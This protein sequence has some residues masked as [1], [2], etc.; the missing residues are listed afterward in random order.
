MISGTASYGGNTII[1]AGT[2]SLSGT[3]PNSP[4]IIVA[5]NAVFDISGTSL[6]LSANQMLSGVGMVIGTLNDNNVVSGS[7]VSP[8]GNGTAGTLTMGGLFLNGNV[9]LNFDLANTTGV[10]GG[11]NDLLVVTN[12]I[13]NVQSVPQSLLGPAVAMAQALRLVAVGCISDAR[14]CG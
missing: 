14:Q 2:L 5:S 10:G 11:T 3:L 12:L 13:A 6:S 9:N 1:S 4:V 8:A 7:A